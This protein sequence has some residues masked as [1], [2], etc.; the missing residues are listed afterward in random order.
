MGVKLTDLLIIK[1]I[2]FDDLKNKVIAVDASVFLYQFLTTIRQRDGSL[3]VDSKGRVTSHLMGLFTRTINLLEKSIKPVFVFDG[4]PPK[5]KHLTQR[6]RAE[7]K[8]EALN[9]YKE[10]IAKGYFEEAKK[11]ASR[12]SKLTKEMIDEAKELIQYFGL[13]I[14]QAPSE[15]EAQ[16]AF[17]V[18]QGNAFGVASQD[19]DSLVFGSPRLIRNLSI[20]GRKKIK[21][22]LSYKQTNPELID[23]TENLNNLGIDQEQLIVLAIIIGTDYNP[24]GV[25]GLGPKKALSLVKKFGKDFDALF[26][27]INWE[28]DFSWREVF[29]LIRNIPTTEDY[30]IEFSSINK[31]GIIRLLCEEH[32]FSEER[33]NK[34]LEP[35]L[36]KKSQ[37]DLSSFF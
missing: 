1:Q 30:K 16:C 23:L 17:I 37:V 27:S 9:K 20:T 3:L 14:V 5:L 36:K 22:K 8:E 4:E 2:S 6:I 34:L 18:K 12:T 24:G 25:K 35:L 32:D 11:Y 10:A 31:E 21:D 29:D 28:F 19:E 15:A 7:A 26:K 33:V 13:P